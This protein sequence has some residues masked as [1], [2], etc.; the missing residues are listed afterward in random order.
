MATPDPRRRL[1]Q[2]LR[3]L[4]GN[5]TE[6]RHAAEALERDADYRTAGVPVPA[7]VWQAIESLEQWARS[8]Q[9]QP[10]ERPWRQSPGT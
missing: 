5:V 8:I 4:R 3:R 2:A 7:E 10:P 1:L 9:A 6:V